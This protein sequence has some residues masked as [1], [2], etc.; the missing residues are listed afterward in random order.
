MQDPRKSTLGTLGNTQYIVPVT[1]KLH[2]PILAYYRL[3]LKKA[4]HV[5]INVHIKDQCNKT[6]NG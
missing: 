5:L 2:L 3:T 4:K 6:N 1:V